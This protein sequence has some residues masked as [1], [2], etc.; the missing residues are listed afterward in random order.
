MTTAPD[1][2]FQGLH[3]SIPDLWWGG[4]K[5]SLHA[6]TMCVA[7]E[8]GFC[9]EI[10]C[11]GKHSDERKDK[12]RSGDFVIRVSG[13]GLEGTWDK[14]RFTHNDL[15]RDIAAKLE[16]DATWVREHLLPA[17]CE[18]TKGD[19][20][21]LQAHCALHP[22]TSPLPGLQPLCFLT[23]L[24]TLNLCEWRR[25]GH[26][27]KRGGG[28]WLPLKFIAAIIYGWSL[29]AVERAQKQG[30]RG[31]AM[32]ASVQPAVPDPDTIC[33]EANAR[34]PTMINQIAGAK[35]ESASIR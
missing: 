20:T 30:L 28:R 23:A 33:Q 35:T 32:L 8:D 9:V 31:Y 25:Y 22:P 18:V 24:Q 4:D 34:R 27:E 13:E 17:L 26:N 5:A 2:T 14:R 1:L 11:P 10:A 21:P 7:E 15:L 16:A 29:E 19:V 6:Q 12:S 3:A